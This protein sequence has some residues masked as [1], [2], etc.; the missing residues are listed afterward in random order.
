MDYCNYN[1]WKSCICLSFYTPYSLVHIAFHSIS[2]EVSDFRI[3]MPFCSARAVILRCTTKISSFG[4]RQEWDNLSS[5]K[6]FNCER[7]RISIDSPGGRPLCMV[8]F[9]SCQLVNKTSV[10]TG[11]P[12][13]N[14]QYMQIRFGSFTKPRATA[15]GPYLPGYEIEATILW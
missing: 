3:H 14:R 9:I 4:M 15:F 7:A 2:R 1:A 8:A 5:S 10:H 12:C 6:A 11:E 13:M